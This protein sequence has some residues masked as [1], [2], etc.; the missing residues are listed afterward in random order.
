MINHLFNWK[1]VLIW[2]YSTSFFQQ[3]FSLTRGRR[4]CSHGSSPCSPAASGS[5]HGLVLNKEK[6]VFSSSQVDHLGHVVDAMQCMVCGR[7]RQVGWP[8]HSS[9][10]PP[11]RARAWEFPGDGELL[12]PFPPPRQP[13]PSSRWRTPH[14]GPGG[15][16]TRVQWSQQI[17]SA[18]KQAKTAL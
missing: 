8:S 16:N 15:H 7:C 9:H 1:M 13:P 4:W 3:M 14:V 2:S 18:F 12:S 11:Q 17:D 10:H 6:C 5:P